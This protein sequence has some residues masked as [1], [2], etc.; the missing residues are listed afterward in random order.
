MSCAPVVSHNPSGWHCTV[1]SGL[2][3]SRKPVSG[4]DLLQRAPAAAQ[5]FVKRGH[6]GSEVRARA[7]CPHEQAQGSLELLA[8]QLF[9][10]CELF[11]LVS[12]LAELAYGQ[13]C[14]RE[15]GVERPATPCNNVAEL[16]FSLADGCA[17]AGE[18]EGND[19]GLLW[20]AASA[21]QREEVVHIEPCAVAEN[22]QEGRA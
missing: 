7:G 21:V 9:G 13:V 2:S 22:L 1:A 20:H 17:N 4:V 8:G 14:R 16:C 18:E 19:G 10:A 5:V 11:Q 15:V 6:V 3:A 12:Q